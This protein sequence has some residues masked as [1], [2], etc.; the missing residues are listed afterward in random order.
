VLLWCI[1][2]LNIQ[3]YLKKCA[4]FY[5]LPIEDIFILELP[6]KNL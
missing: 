1:F 4:F 2:V 3:K 5:K 6:N